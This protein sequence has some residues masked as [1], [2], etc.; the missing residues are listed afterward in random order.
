[1]PYR[2]EKRKAMID[3]VLDGTP[4]DAKRGRFEASSSTSVQPAVGSIEA[5]FEEDVRR[6]LAR[7]SMSTKEITKT[8]SKKR[9]DMGKEELMTL[10]ANAIKRIKPNRKKIKGT[11]Y[12]SLEKQ[13]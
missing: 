11:L 13:W 2:A 1:M 7:K 10:L 8:M 5:S 12:L 3:R 4:N 9:P 6:Y